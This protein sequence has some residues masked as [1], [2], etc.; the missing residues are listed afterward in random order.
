LSGSDIP[1]SETTKGDST[2]AH[3]ER[4]NYFNYFTEVEDEFVRRRGKQLLISPMDWAL[5]E[6][7][8]NAGIP[9]HI[10]LRAINEAFD[11]YDKRGQQHRK[12]NSIFYCQQQVESD[13]ADY[14]LAQVGGESGDSNI[15]ETD[16]TEISRKSEVFPK[17]ILFAFLERCDA[18]LGVAASR[19]S[20][21]NKTNLESAIARA[22]SRIKEITREIER[23]SSVDA[24]GLERD[25]DSI[26]RII[27]E[28]ARETLGPEELQSIRKEGES[29]L[30]SYRKKM[31]KAIYEQTVQNFISRRLR[32]LNGI[33]RMSLFYL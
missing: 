1:A 20:E 7:W 28:S 33:P 27:L 25:L 31:D 2:V 8:K 3:P 10:V 14:R 12:V 21:S 19:A 24:E 17:T 30:R 15:T 4:L 13:F 23:V 9:L 11:A 32:E 18:D 29:Q 22:R 16:A 26:D 6:S 5:V